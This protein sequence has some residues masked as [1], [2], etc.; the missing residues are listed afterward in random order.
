M[1]IILVGAGKVGEHLI[2]NFI[3]E[4]HDVVVV[5]TNSKTIENLVEKYD[6]K[7]V[8][9]GGFEREVL[10]EAGVDTADFI[11]AST[12]RDELNILCCVI[13]KKLGAKYTIARVRDPEYYKERDTVKE[14]LGLDYVF[15]PEYRTAREIFRVLK[16]PSALNIEKFA[17]GKA[18]MAEFEV[19]ENSVICNCTIKEIIGIAGKGVLFAYVKR[20]NDAFIPKGDF[21]VKDKDHIFVVASEEE[22]ADFCKKLKIFVKPVK[23]TLIIGG[24][25]IGY[26]LANNL[27]KSG[28][29]VKIIEKSRERAEEL[30]KL[31]PGIAVVIGDGTDKE[32]L[33]EEGLN[34]YEACVTLTGMDEEN[35]IISLYAKQSVS[36]VVTKLDRESVA[37][38]VTKLGLESVVSPKE[39][40][41]NNIVKFVRSHSSDD[42]NRLNSLYKLDDGVEALEFTVKED[43]A[44][45]EIPLKQ[46]TIKNYA[47]IAGIV[48]GDNF[49]LPGGDTVMKIADKVIVVVNSNEITELD[50]LFK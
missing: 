37:D 12:S 7:G 42:G 10:L 35:V 20:E 17:K 47:I 8:V 16:F 32:L 25:K 18:I 50:M 48:R 11:I 6:V 43:F 46:L 33:E 45:K 44:F 2:E 40:I 41:A 1:K 14:N 29:S 28:V 21:I 23:N 22:V 15:N 39:V 24:G 34:N 5:D 36:K 26:Y 9:G 49:I 31:I 3:K 38:M 19:P 30:S 27:I 13:A 4:K